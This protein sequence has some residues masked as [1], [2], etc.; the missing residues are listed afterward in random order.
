MCIFQ[1]K[2]E[3]ASV[4]EPLEATTRNQEALSE[5]S[6]KA[7]AKP[8]T[9]KDT[10]SSIIYGGGNKKP[11]EDPNKA[12]RKRGTQALSIALNAGNQTGG[13]INV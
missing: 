9:D 4:L 1:R 11:T 7:D 6:L 8:L 10:A 3:F 2:P 5:S 12:T 13:G